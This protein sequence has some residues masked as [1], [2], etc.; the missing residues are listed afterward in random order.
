MRLV[1]IIH[2]QAD[3][4]DLTKTAKTADPWP[5]LNIINISTSFTRSKCDDQK[6]TEIYLPLAVV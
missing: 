5:G 4:L 1:Q 2:F 6:L 3:Y